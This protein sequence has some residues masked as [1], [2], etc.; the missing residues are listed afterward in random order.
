MF[1]AIT[2][3]PEETAAVARRLATALG[4]GDVLAFRGGLGAGKTAFVSALVA[5][6][7]IADDV[8]SPT[9]ALMNEYSGASLTVYHFDLYRIEDLDSLYAT[10]FFDCLDGKAL[11]AVEWSENVEEAVPAGAVVISMEITGDTQRKITIEGKEGM[12]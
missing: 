4:P 2:N 6:L 5:A 3:S 8:S 1:T 9:F 11:V 10:G 7:G 12:L